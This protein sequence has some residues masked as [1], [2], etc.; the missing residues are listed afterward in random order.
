MNKQ[1]EAKFDDWKV[2]SDLHSQEC[3][4]SQC[5]CEEQ[6]KSFISQNYISRREVEEKLEKINQRYKCVA[7]DGAKCEHTMLCQAT[8][9]FKKLL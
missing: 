1:E 5:R 8:E 4:I 6:I 7:C 9:D 3:E 2:L